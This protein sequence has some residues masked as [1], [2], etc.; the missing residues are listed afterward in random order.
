MASSPRAQQVRPPLPPPLHSQLTPPRR[1]ALPARGSTSTYARRA[2][3]S[4]RARTPANTTAGTLEV[5]RTNPLTGASHSVLIDAS[6]FGSGGIVGSTINVNFNG[7]REELGDHSIL[8][9]ASSSGTSSPANSSSPS[10]AGGIHESTINLTVIS[11]LRR[12]LVSLLPSHA[13]RAVHPTLRARQAGFV[14]DLA[15]QESAYS[16]AVAALYTLS[17]P[18]PIATATASVEDVRIFA[19]LDP[20][21]A[22]PSLDSLAAPTP[23]SNPLG[24]DILAVLPP[25]T[26]TMTLV[27]GPSGYVDAAGEPP[28]PVATAS[29]EGTGTA[30]LLVET[31]K[32]GIHVVSL[33]RRD[34]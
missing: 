6:S 19:M 34:E 26:L 12:A 20:L 29:V 11:R 16:A 23:S 4:R 22:S 31:M 8:V 15:A 14:S 13:R 2:R 5:T 7:K 28:V 10:T 25:L 18:A 1:A 21:L 27:A 30:A 17:T 9:D 24:A 32:R 3:L 33:V